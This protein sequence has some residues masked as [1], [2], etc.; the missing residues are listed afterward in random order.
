MTRLVTLIATISLAVPAPALACHHRHHRH[1]H[2]RPGLVCTNIQT[3]T[4]QWL[5]EQEG[6]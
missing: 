6:K 1:H 5:C 2:H 4:I 3:M